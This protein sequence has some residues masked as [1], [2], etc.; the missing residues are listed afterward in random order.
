M[1]PTQIALALVVSVLTLRY[2]FHKISFSQVRE[3][4]G[5]EDESTMPMPITDPQL[6]VTLFLIFKKNSE[7]E[8]YQFISRRLY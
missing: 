8:N 6:T 5:N 2:L 4:G 3:R 1:T 7:V